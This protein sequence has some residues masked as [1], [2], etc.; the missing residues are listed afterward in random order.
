MRNAPKF[1]FALILTLA[2]CPSLY[3][4]RSSAVLLNGGFSTPGFGFDFTHH[5]AVN[6]DIGVRALIDPITQQQLALER[7]IRRET[8]VFPGAFPVVLNSTQ[9]IVMPPAPVV[10]VVPQQQPPPE[11]SGREIIDAIERIERL[12]HSNGNA[13]GNP[14]NEGRSDAPGAVRDALADPPGAHRESADL[15]FI[16]RDG[17]LVFAV[18]FST[19]SDRI[20]YVTREGHRRSL[21][22]SDLD[23]PATLEMN[24]ARGTTLK[25]L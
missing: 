10:V 3:A 21:L 16:R 24:E 23:V 18:A 5:A 20:V 7:Q 22:L 14:G 13:A 17:N 11:N 12:H 8:P 19:R 4:Q 2:A 1:A 9:V 6:R 25:I 15:V